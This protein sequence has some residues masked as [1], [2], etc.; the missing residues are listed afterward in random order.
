MFSN[1]SNEF[2]NYVKDGENHYKGG[3]SYLKKEKPT[4]ELRSGGGSASCN[5]LLK[6]SLSKPNYTHYL[7]HNVR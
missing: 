5:N 7:F 2:L 6:S 4:K 1:F 3:P